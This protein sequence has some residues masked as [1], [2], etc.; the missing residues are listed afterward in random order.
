[1][2]K[3]TLFIIFFFLI[4]INKSNSRKVSS[5]S[6]ARDGDTAYNS[7]MMILSFICSME[8]NVKSDTSN[9]SINQFIIIYNKNNELIKKL[10]VKKIE[11]KNG[12]CWITDQPI[13]RYKTYFTTDK[14]KVLND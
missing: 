2:I 10:K 14:C 4:T 11:Y 6:W 5:V 3:K 8:Q 12:R 9:T 13:R 7:C 1:M